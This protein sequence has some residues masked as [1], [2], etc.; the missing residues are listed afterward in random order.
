MSNSLIRQEVTETSQDTRLIDIAQSI[1]LLNHA[2]KA[3]QQGL[4]GVTSPLEMM[5]LRAEN[6]EAA[7]KA[8]DIALE[9]LKVLQANSYEIIK[10]SDIAIVA[11]KATIKANDVDA[12]HKQMALNELNKVIEK[13]ADNLKA[14][15]FAFN[16]VQELAFNDPLTGLPNRRLLKDRLEQSIAHNKRWGTHSAA[17]FLDLDK[18]KTL[19]DQFGHEVG[20]ELLIAVA[21][22][23]KLAVRDSDTV[24]RF[25]GDEFVILLDELNE[26]FAE[27]RTE[28][29]GIANKL[30]SV[31]TPAHELH[32]RRDARAITTVKY[33]NFASFGVVIFNGDETKE[34]NILD[35]ADEAM[36]WAKS[37]GGRTV[38]FYDAVASTE[39]T[40]K[41]LYDLTTE[42]D[43]ETANHGVRMQ[44]YVK[45]LANRALQMNLFP[46]ELNHQII[47]KLFRATQLHDIGKTKIP[48]SILHKK[49]KLT[50]EE[51]AVIKT[52]TNCGAEILE[53]AKRQNESLKEFL[54][55]AIDIALG[56]HERWDGHGYPKG[57]AGNQIP[58]AGR[59]IAIA[60]VY[61]ALISRR[62]YKEPW[63]HEDALAELVSHSGKQFD[64]LLIEALMREQQNFRQIAESIKD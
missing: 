64:P 5:Q 22:R 25:G 3:D 24:A 51:W 34:K 9:A 21:N 14:S 59:I 45:A 1:D 13:N 29:E 46:G 30:L 33:Q 28:A 50:D 39:Q 23:L 52:H 7:L 8:S 62:S 53:E 26:N 60:D 2:I 11:M 47:E 56:H 38:R 54:N 58:L 17:I 48:Y 15:A 49:S 55:I 27:A 61:D 35:W 63:Q 16:A 20:D 41:K 43:I 42:N 57:L 36:Y 44:H 37:E 32:I 18:F 10:A 40:L 6:A 4:S 19:N 31:I 12:H